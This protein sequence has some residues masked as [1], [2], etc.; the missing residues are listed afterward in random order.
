MEKLLTISIAA[1][2]AEAYIEKTLKSLIIPEKMDRL[3]VFIIDDGGKDKTLEIAEQFQRLY[4]DTFIPVHKE[5]GGYG[6]TVNYSIAHASG[7][8]YKILDGDDWADTEALDKLLAVLEKD[9][10]DAIITNYYKAPEG[11]ELELI[12][13]NSY[14]NGT[15]K[16]VCSGFTT[17]R[18]FDMW[19]LVYKTEILI[20]SR[21]EL[22]L[23]V[24]YTDRYYATIPFALV[25][26]IS[27]YDFPVYCYRIGR[28]GQSM[29]TESQIKHYKERLSGS[30]D[31]CRFYEHERKNNNPRCPYLLQKVVVTHVNS[32][33]VI[34]Y[35]PK[36]AESARILKEYEDS[37]YGISKEIAEQE[38]YTRRFGK[39]LSWCRKT[40]FLLYY[41]TPDYILKKTNTNAFS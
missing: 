9:D 7:K 35:M 36:S 11:G 17:A 2:N 32:A 33:S 25:D 40:R 14:P 24:L 1:Y 28:D 12:E 38:Q 3:E 8:Y 13:T 21:L 39:F 10:A 20:K 34:T 22:P 15:R 27:F 29:S 30:I 23:H 41:L 19:E 18:P 6:S 31:L 26:T 16:S 5:N 37:V 4:P